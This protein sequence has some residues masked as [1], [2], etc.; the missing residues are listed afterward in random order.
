MAPEKGSPRAGA[1]ASG[2]TAPTSPGSN[3]SAAVPHAAHAHQ[4]TANNLVSVAAK[5][6]RQL[7]EEAQR[8]EPGVLNAS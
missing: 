6:K 2:G 7:E 1:V 8:D 5:G 3:R 4:E